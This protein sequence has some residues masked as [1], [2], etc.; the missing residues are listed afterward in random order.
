MVAIGGCISFSRERSY[1]D[2]CF[3]PLF[4]G[5]SGGEGGVVGALD[6]PTPLLG[7][8][9]DAEGF[10]DG[11]LVGGGVRPEELEGAAATEPGPEGLAIA[12]STELWPEELEDAAAV[13]PR[14]ENVAASDSAEPW[15]EDVAEP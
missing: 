12:D 3:A 4:G 13:E 11:R 14:P 5:G 7:V 1:R 9:V 6:D 15:P 8:A 10:E 2:I